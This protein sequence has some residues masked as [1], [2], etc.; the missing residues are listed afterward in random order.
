M[1]R[2]VIC[3]SGDT[4]IN[5]LVRDDL[6]PVLDGSYAMTCCATLDEVRTAARLLDRKGDVAAIVVVDGVARPFGDVVGLAELTQ[7]NPWVKTILLRGAMDAD[8][9]HWSGP[10]VDRVL[11][12]LA[13]GR[14]LRV[15][16]RELLARWTYENPELTRR[17][18]SRPATPRRRL[19]AG[20]VIDEDLAP[21]GS[22][23]WRIS[24]LTDAVGVMERPGT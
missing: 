19:R 12:R 3:I 18:A 9:L 7:R 14:A 17:S 2:H 21:S 22:G 8:G 24:A 5:K 16:V 4:T 6:E 13:I 1:R 10:D 11:P 20:G 15:T 23:M